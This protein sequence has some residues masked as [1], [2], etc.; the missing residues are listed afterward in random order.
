MRQSLSAGIIAQVCVATLLLPYTEAQ[1]GNKDDEKESVTASEFYVGFDVERRAYDIFTGVTTAANG[2]MEKSGVL[3]RAEAEYSHF[4][5]QSGDL[6]TVEGNQP[7]GSVLLGYQWVRKN[8]TFAAFIGPDF[9]NVSL[10]PNDPAAKVKG[11]EAGAKVAGEFTAEDE[12]PLSLRIRGNYSTAFDSYW[13]RIRTGYKIHDFVVGPELTA[14]GDDS[15]NARKAGGFV[16]VPVKLILN[17]PMEISVSGG[18]Q[19]VG[20][21][22]GGGAGGESSAGGTGGYLTVN[23]SGEF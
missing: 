15:F 13:A 23:L 17:K 18:F 14:E 5:Y 12:G 11:F 4:S 16:S 1:A 10:A 9:E 22:G 3:L 20:E 6:G 8:Y 7:S 19:W 21:P 2:N